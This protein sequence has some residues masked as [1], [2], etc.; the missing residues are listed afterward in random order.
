M[1]THA[2]TSSP[3]TL[4]R[5][6]ATSE[7]IV[8]YS[9]EIWY[10]SKGTSSKY[11][12]LVS[13]VAP[14]WSQWLSKPYSMRVASESAAVAKNDEAWYEV[15]SLS[16]ASQRPNCHCPPCV[17]NEEHNTQAPY[18]QEEAREVYSVQP[19]YFADIFEDWQLH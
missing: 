2:A 8:I 16:Q 7:D 12:S 5:F 14:K 11:G 4:L 6:K 17:F 10:A 13:C 19:Y 3:A 1:F 18:Y 9:S 15:F